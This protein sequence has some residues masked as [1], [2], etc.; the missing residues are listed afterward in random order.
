MK[1]AL[2]VCR[3]IFSYPTSRYP[4]GGLHAYYLSDRMPVD[5]LMLARR[6]PGE[7]LPIG[8][9]VRLKRLFCPNPRVQGVR[10]H[11][12]QLFRVAVKFAG[13]L[14]FALQSAPFMLLQRPQIV[15][16]HA[17]LPLP[18]GLLG[19]LLRAKVVLTLHGTEFHS[20]RRSRL[21]Q[22][23][24]RF[25]CDAIF[26]VSN[27]MIEP[28]LEMFPNTRIVY[29]PSGVD[30]SVFQRAETERKRQII[31]VG[32]L[33]WEKGYPVL[34]RAFQRVLDRL[35]DYALVIVGDGEDR[36]SLMKLADDLGLED[37]VVFALQQPQRRVAEM[38][39]ESD[40]FVMSSVSE[41]F[42]KVL[43]EALACGLP[44]VVTDVGSCGELVRNNDV[45]KVVPPNDDALLGDAI[46]AMLSDRAYHDECVRRSGPVARK[47]E[48]SH[49]AN[50]VHHEYQNILAGA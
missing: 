31:A 3:V 49:V 7:P 36:D 11:L 30:L 16:I 28:L 32:L 24:V 17:I 21:M 12:V 33:K 10:S 19:K 45:G 29:T 18:L 38:L 35:P 9:S 39:G 8:P 44:L 47:Y 46:V 4:G 20:L 13:V 50:L 27:A 22:A 2:R 37:R 15:H 1:G 40:L 43:L 6:L 23:A 25:T 41:G 26:C 42:P 48:W 5:S 14:V 34:L